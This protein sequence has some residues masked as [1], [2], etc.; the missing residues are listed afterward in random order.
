MA[1]FGG[2]DRDRPLPG[3]PPAAPPAKPPGVEA[4]KSAAPVRGGHTVIGS[5]VKITG[6]LSGDEDVEICGRVEGTVNLRQNLT[7][8]A[9]GNV[10]AKVHAKNVVIAGRVKGD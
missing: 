10:E 8:A 4:V 7:V 6:E 9:A 5:Q 2:K 3:V 1:L